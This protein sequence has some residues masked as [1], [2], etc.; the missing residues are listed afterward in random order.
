MSVGLRPYL[1]ASVPQNEEDIVMPG[2]KYVHIQKNMK[3]L[4]WNLNL[5]LS[6][7]GKY[8]VS[9]STHC[10]HEVHYLG[11]N[12]KN[13]TI[14]WH[15]VLFDFKGVHIF[16]FYFLPVGM[17][18]LRKIILNHLYDATSRRVHSGLK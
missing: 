2:K 16:S 3:I 15:V 14:M 6:I 10:V 1:S 9:I 8:F 17:V 18:V 13:I 11:H 5:V 4:Y 12:N 7:F